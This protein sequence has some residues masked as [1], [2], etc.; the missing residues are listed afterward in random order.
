MKTPVSLNRDLLLRGLSF[1][2]TEF[3]LSGDSNGPLTAKNMKGDIYVFMPLRSAEYQ[4]TPVRTTKETDTAIK[5]NNKMPEKKNTPRNFSV[6]SPE[7]GEP[8]VR[9]LQHITITQEKAKAVVEETK[10]LTRLLKEV[11]RDI[12][13]REKEFKDTRAIIDRLKKVS[14]F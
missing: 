12:R 14:G 5:E 10:E 6:V 1:G 8:M 3:D 4:D 11:Q 2:F 13:S 9:L 7:E